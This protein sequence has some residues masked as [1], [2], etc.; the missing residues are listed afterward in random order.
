MMPFASTMLFGYFEIVL[1]GKIKFPNKYYVN[2]VTRKM[3][4]LAKNYLQVT[5]STVHM[6]SG[7]HEAMITKSKRNNQLFPKT[8]I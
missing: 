3:T 7:D 8:L 5:H 4:T 6:N 1:D 2:F